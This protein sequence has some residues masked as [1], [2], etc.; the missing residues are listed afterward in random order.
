MSKS[1]SSFACVLVKSQAIFARCWTLSQHASV[2]KSFWQVAARTNK[3]K[4][5]Y[6]VSGLSSSAQNEER[7]PHLRCLET[8]KPWHS[9]A[10]LRRIDNCRERVGAV[11]CL[12][13]KGT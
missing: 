11:H 8:Q 9:L 7:R 10:N 12:Y 5:L 1:G 13:M 3:V 6:P 4:T 2:Q